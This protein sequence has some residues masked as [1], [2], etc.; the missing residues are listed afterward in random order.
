MSPNLN[1]PEAAVANSDKNADR[2][3]ADADFSHTSFSH[4]PYWMKLKD[5]YAKRE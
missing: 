4:H 2:H 3:V 5:E 1:E